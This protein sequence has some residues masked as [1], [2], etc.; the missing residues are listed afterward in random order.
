MAFD[1]NTVEAEE[2]AAVAL[3]GVHPI[4]QHGESL[5]REQGADLGQP[6]PAHRALEQFG[7]LTSRALRRLDG[8]IAGKPFGDH[9]VD[10]TLANVA[11]LDEPDILQLR[12]LGLAQHPS[13][14]ADLLEPLDFLDA[15]I[16][17]TDLRALE[18]EHDARHGAAHDR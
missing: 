3:P 6:G 7:K 9:D 8:D 11:S 2:H 13:S 4:A 15:D 5:T 18:V 12:Q 10:D 14:L 1:D 17:E 16:Q